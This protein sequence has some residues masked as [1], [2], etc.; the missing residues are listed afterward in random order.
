MKRIPVSSSNI[1][2]AGYDPI[3]RSLEI[4]FLH[5]GTYQYSDVPTSVYDSL[6]TAESHGS[7]FDRHIKKA[8]YGYQKVLTETTLEIQK[9]IEDFELKNSYATQSEMISY[10]NNEITPSL[11]HRFSAALKACGESIIDEF[12]LENKY[13]KV[14]KAT[15]K[16]WLQ[17]D[18]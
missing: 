17:P 6:M 7:Y 1:A 3:T 11:K 2:S 8:G 16:G 9:L 18:G 14:I 15:L 12:W 5:G 13:H 10:V 4:E